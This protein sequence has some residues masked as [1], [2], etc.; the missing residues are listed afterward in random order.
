MRRFGFAI[1]A[2]ALMVAG[3]TPPDNLPEEGGGDDVVLPPSELTSIVA[4]IDNQTRVSATVGADETVRMFW[5]ATD[6]LLVTDRAKMATF[7]L[8]SGD[9]SNTATFSGGL[10]IGDKPIYALYP[11]TSANLGASGKVLVSIPEEQTYSAVRGANLK[12]KLVL[13]GHSED[14]QT[15]EFTPAGSIIRFDVKLHEGRE[16]R[17]VKMSIERLGLTG[18]GEVDLASGSIGVTDTKSVTLSYAAPSKTTSSDGWVFV[19]PI[20]FKSAVGDIYYD[21]ETDAGAY[22]FCYNPDE[23]FV[24]GGI[25]TISLSID[26][27]ERAPMKEALSEGKYYCDIEEKEDDGNGDGDGDD[28]EIVDPDAGKLVQGAIYYTDGTPAVGVSV[29]DGFTVVQTAADG[30]YSFEP[31]IDT[32]YVYYSLPA[33]AKVQVN[34]KGQPTFFTK[35]DET[36]SI[37][38]FRLT[39]MEGGKENRFSLFCLADPQCATSANRTRFVQESVPDIREHVATKSWS[40]YG[41]TLGDIVSSGDS[42]NTQPQMPYMR[43]HMSYDRVGLPIFQ[44]MGNH[45]Y[46]YFNGS[47]PLAADETSSTPNIKAQRAFED[48]FGP[49]NY[50]W[51]RGDTH[52]VS[53]RDMLWTKLTSGGGYKLAFSDE[54]VEWLRQDLSFVPKDKLVI[55]CVHIPLVNS[56]EKSVQQVISMLAEY[57]EAHIMSGHTHYM[58]NEPTLSKGV[59]E[60]VHAAVCGAWWYANTNGDGSPNGYGVY[61]IEGNTIKNWYYKGVNTNMDDVSYQIRLYRGDHKSGGSKEYYAQQ[62]GDG[63]LLANVFNSDPSWTVKVYEN[64]TYTGNMVRMPNKKEI[65]AKGTGVDNPTKPS[66]NSSQDWWAIG[67]LV[68]VKGRSRDSYSTNGFHLYKYTLKDKNAAVRVEATDQFGNVYS[69]TTITEDYDYSLMSVK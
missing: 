33:D 25:Y 6:E 14:N 17:S 48:L 42:R 67:Y 13:F 15:F 52:I 24:A 36:T 63:V 27:F 69:A 2:F 64:G 39:K 60:H 22:T 45:D 55:L 40:C 18:E 59:Y 20:N 54:Q 30:T 7:K 16:I 8:T 1:F 49:I 35:Y 65:P 10:A 61:D 57:Q 32:W 37:Y 62:H 28:E 21:I 12:D 50:S 43:D 66:V 11:A 44:T 38:N 53:M 29:S 5:S 3:C 58:R 41:V 46:T 4:K 9:G 23:K 34:D 26:D 51:N 31:H 56:S 47:D 19:A 68:G